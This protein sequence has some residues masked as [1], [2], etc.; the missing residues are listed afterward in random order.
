MDLSHGLGEQDLLNCKQTTLV[1]LLP[2]SQFLAPTV[3]LSLARGS[4]REHIFTFPTHSD[5]FRDGNATQV[6]A[7]GILVCAWEIRFC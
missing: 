5:C 6:T 1:D 4:D 7:E 3:D 2:S